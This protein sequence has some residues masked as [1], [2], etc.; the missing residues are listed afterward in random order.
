MTLTSIAVVR[1]RGGAPASRAR[2]TRDPHM[3][4]P[5]RAPFLLALVFVA[6]IGCT[7]TE[8]HRTLVTHRPAAAATPYTGP[9]QAIALGKFDNRSGTGGGMFS[10]GV[11]RLGGQARTILQGHLHSTG[12]FDVLD[13]DNLEELAR[14]A[15]LSGTQQALDGAEFALT[16][17]IVEFG[18]REVGDKACWG[19]L[20]RGRTHVAYAK[21]TVNVVR[22]ATARV[23][24]SAQGAG[25]Y[26]LASSEVLGIGSTAGYDSTLNGKV[27][28]LAMREAVDRLVE[29]YAA[30]AWK[31]K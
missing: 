2:L 21:V 25:E 8:G 7:T 1:S 18:R 4:K 17:D 9:R 5:L 27:L 15:S 10:S 29:S 14:E 31:A 13:R 24:T 28:D 6:A 3:H 23:V 26:T 16:G 19:I 22:V 11:D 12:R 20:G 30:G